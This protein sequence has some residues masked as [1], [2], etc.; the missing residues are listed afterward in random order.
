MLDAAND[1]KNPTAA[2]LARSSVPV[3]ISGNS[4]SMLLMHTVSRSREGLVTVVSHSDTAV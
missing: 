2:N 4:L 3:S 1:F